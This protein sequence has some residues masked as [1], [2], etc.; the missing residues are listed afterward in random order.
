MVGCGPVA[1]LPMRFSSRCLYV[2]C[3][4]PVC[5]GQAAPWPPPH[6]GHHLRYPQGKVQS[7]E[8][9]RP[10]GP[11]KNCENSLSAPFVR[12]DL[13]GLNPPGDPK[14]KKGAN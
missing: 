9:M 6:L 8:I 13:Q 4:C 11:R 7:L 12:Y 5:L 10:P 2:L 14:Q 1:L 3:M